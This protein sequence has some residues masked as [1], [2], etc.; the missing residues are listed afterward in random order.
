MLNKEHL[1]STLAI[2]VSDFDNVDFAELEAEFVVPRTV[3]TS[4]EGSEEEPAEIP[5]EEGE[6]EEVE[7]EAGLGVQR[8]RE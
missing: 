4:R 2:G 7:M 3:D 8:G 5:D 1:T 6:V